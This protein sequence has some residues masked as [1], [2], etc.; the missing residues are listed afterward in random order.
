MFYDE[1]LLWF[2]KCEPMYFSMIYVCD[3][4]SMPSIML[5]RQF[6]DVYEIY[7]MC[8]RI[9]GLDCILCAL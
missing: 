2:F 5:K 9:C 4:L 8:L 1:K 7:K 3:L 6:D